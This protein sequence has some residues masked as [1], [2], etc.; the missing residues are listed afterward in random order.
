LSNNYYQIK[1]AE[2][3]FEESIKNMR[4]NQ[5]YLYYYRTKYKDLLKIDKNS[6][7][8]LT[9]FI[10]DDDNAEVLELYAYALIEVKDYANASKVYEKLPLDKM[11]KFADDINNDGAKE[12][13]LGLYIKSIE[14]ATDQIIIA[15]INLKCANILFEMNDFEKS[16][17]Y[18]QSIINN[19]EI[20]SNQLRYRTRANRE[21]RLMMALIS[22]ILDMQIE[23][24]SNWYKEAINFSN[25]LMEKADILFSFSKYLYLKGDFAGSYQAIE[26]AVDKQDI[27]TSIYRK[28]N[29][30]RYEMAL[31]QGDDILRDSL[32]VECII[33]FP[34]D[35]RINDMLFLESFISKIDEK[36]RPAFL[37]AL[38]YRGLLQDKKTIK[39]IL[40]L[41]QESKI[42]ELYLLAFEWSDGTNNDEILKRLQDV[43]FSNEAF[44]DYMFLQ[45]LK[46]TNDADYRKH[47]ISDF[48]N[49][50]P[51]NVFSP[52]LRML[53]FGTTTRE[54]I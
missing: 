17:Y 48:L 31:F 28:S 21:A 6:I 10:K 29:F 25:N 8:K 2:S 50:N 49:N 35:E 16:Q 41:A 9:K 22:T 47:Q 23:S 37:D 38:R 4:Y 32:L 44:K 52:H 39:I 26:Q 53:L 11:L 20:Q 14:K 42:Q 3:F 7:K 24:V 54:Q 30:Y 34:E 5:G 27:T 15:D 45:K 36:Y 19:T 13:A 46:T 12:Y 40:D 1:N 18:L 33:Y 51:R 43:E